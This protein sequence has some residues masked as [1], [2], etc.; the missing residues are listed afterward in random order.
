MNGVLRISIRRRALRVVLVGHVLQRDSARTRLR[1]RHHRPVRR[2][3]R[4]RLSGAGEVSGIS[5]TVAAIRAPMPLCR[6]TPGVRGTCASAAYW[7]AAACRRVVAVENPFG[8][9]RGRHLLARHCAEWAEK[10]GARYRSVSDR[11]PNKAPE[12]G[13]ASAMR[14]A[15]HSRRDGRRVPRTSDACAARGRPDA[16][17]EFYQGGRMLAA[18]AAR[19]AGW[20]DAV[21]TSQPSGADAWLM[22]GGAPPQVQRAPMSHVSGHAARRPLPQGGRHAQREP[23]G[24]VVTRLP[25]R[26][27]NCSRRSSRASSE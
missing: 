3:P 2:R 22:T 12:P 8:R 1:P 26:T 15:G 10:L 23:G 20:V 24:G 18:N 25:R 13:N 27:R 4:N 21:L 19:D 17:A 16:V 6:S 9:V 11:T 7:L 5:E 14:D